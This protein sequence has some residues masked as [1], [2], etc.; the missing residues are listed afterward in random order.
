MICKEEWP[1]EIEGKALSIG[2]FHAGSEYVKNVCIQETDVDINWPKQTA[3]FTSKMPKLDK[4]ED[5][6]D[7]ND[8]GEESGDTVIKRS[9]DTKREDQKLIKEKESKNI[10]LV[11]D[12]TK[13]IESIPGRIF[14]GTAVKGNR[15]VYWEFG[16]SELNNRH[17]LIFGSSGMGKTYT[18]QCLLCELG[19]VGQN[20]LIID[21]TNGFSENHLEP[22]L[23]KLLNPSQH[24]VRKEPL[25][26]NPFRR[27]EEVYGKERVLENIVN[28][29]QRVAGVFSEV[30]TLGEQQKASLYAA[31]KN[32]L[33]KEVKSEMSLDSLVDKLR[34][35]EDSDAPEGRYAGTI[36]S[37]ITPFVDMNP[38]GPEKE[39]SWDRLFKDMDNRCHIL[40][41]VGF[42]R[43]SWK[44]IVEFA[45]IDLYAYY[46]IMGSQNKP[47]V[48]VLDEVQNLDQREDSPLAQLLRE[49]RKFGFSLILATQIMSNLQKD[50]RDRLFNAGHKLFFRPADTEMRSYADI[51]AVSTGEDVSEWMRRLAQLQ[52]GECYSLGPSKND[53][54]SKL[55]TKAFRIKIASLEERGFNG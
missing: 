32:G 35:L 48:V 41:L 52:K 36:L 20:S 25:P 3:T 39:G 55:E 27:L 33:E 28:T 31:I 17:I 7:Q 45:L 53:V 22:G 50:E 19:K 47:R 4:D 23:I 37:K 15:R 13:G 51:A 2:V 12:A 46:R 8:G 42:M 30:Y 5:D 9:I 40:Q 54:T 16:H 21:Y 38:F 18:I 11:I 10:A 24:I 44:L 6:S 26:I 29:A 34:E 14:L 1:F 49:G 43:D